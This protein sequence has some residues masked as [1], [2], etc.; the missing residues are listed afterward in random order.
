MLK[1][2]PE[3]ELKIMNFIWE[4]NDI[5]TSKDVTFAME[6]KYGWKQTT[7]LTLLAR[8]VKKGFLEAN[9][10]DRYTHYTIIVKDR[11]YKDFETRLFNKSI[12]GN[13]IKSWVTSLINTQAIPEDKIES[14]KELFKD[15]EDE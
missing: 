6:Q 10:I 1:K 5:V 2:I 7:T 4:K 12:H 13:S 8:L 3:A 9:K 15:N 11:E 14:F